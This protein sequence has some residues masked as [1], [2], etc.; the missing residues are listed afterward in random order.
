MFKMSSTPIARKGTFDHG[1]SQHFEGPKA[2][3]QTEKKNIKN[4]IGEMSVHC[5]LEQCNLG[6]LSFSLVKQPDD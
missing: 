1:L 5:Q 6:L 4:C 2:I 3:E